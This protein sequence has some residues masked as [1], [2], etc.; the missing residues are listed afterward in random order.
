[1]RLVRDAAASRCRVLTALRRR[2]P[3]FIVF[4]TCGVHAVSIALTV[5]V[6]RLS[7]HLRVQGDGYLTAH[8]KFMVGVDLPT[9]LLAVRPSLLPCV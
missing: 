5:A 9:R 1:M 4:T 6:L 2:G 7:T 8:L 3:L